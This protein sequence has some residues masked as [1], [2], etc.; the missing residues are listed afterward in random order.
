MPKNEGL[1]LSQSTIEKL[2]YYVYLLKDPKNNKVFY[3][4]KGK[5]NRINHHLLGA[6]DDN[7]KET[8][9]IKRIRD[10]EKSGLEVKK[11]ILR[12]ELTEPEAFA[13]E[14][15]M[16]DYLGINNLTNIVCG[17]H[18]QN[19]GLMDLEDLKI[20]YEAKD[21][22][23]DEPAILI[24]INRLYYKGIKDEE[25]YEA[26]RKHWHIN[27]NRAADIRIACAVYRGII[28][29]VYLINKWCATTGKLRGRHYFI[30]RKADQKTREKYLNKSVKKF[31]KQ[32]SQ[33][34]IKYVGIKN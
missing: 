20:K 33:N 7:T 29:E 14:S 25:I 17:H 15:T 9:K 19:N 28:R 26:T 24:T 8:E 4:G 2:G 21:A 22:V 30:G 18:A 31:W 1:N 23:F 27:I 6:M 13:V 16:I 11:I 12:H 32:G 10:I 5:G 3:V 34:P